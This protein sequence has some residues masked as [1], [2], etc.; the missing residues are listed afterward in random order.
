MNHIQNELLRV[1]WFFVVSFVARSSA[2]SLLLLVGIARAHDWTQFRGPSGDGV[3]AQ[4]QHPHEWSTEKNVAWK[5]AIP[6]VAWS[7][8]VVWGGKVFLTTAV[9][10]GGKKPQ[11]GDWRPSDSP[12]TSLSAT[13]C[14]MTPG[15]STAATT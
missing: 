14:R 15:L 1:L 5:A 12:N 8:P 11:P 7:Q 2:C 10:E 3:A 9:P 4:S 6:G 13:V